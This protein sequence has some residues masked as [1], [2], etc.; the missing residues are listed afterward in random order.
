MKRDLFA[1]LTDNFA[2]VFAAIPAPIA[3]DAHA[4]PPVPVRRDGMLRGRKLQRAGRGAGGGVVTVTVQRVS[5]AFR[6]AGLQASK[7][8]ASGQVRG[9]GEWA[10]GVR[11]YRLDGGN[12]RAYFNHSRYTKET[13]EMIAADIAKLSAALDAANL[14][15]V[16]DGEYV[17]VT[18]VKS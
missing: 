10:A 8:H 7:Y 5:A 3:P 4:R 1:I 13:P 2:A 16:V 18:G 15:Y 14:E 9:W 17:T 6:K 12:V 11:T